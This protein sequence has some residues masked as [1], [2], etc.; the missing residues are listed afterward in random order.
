MLKQSAI[1]ATILHIVVNLIKHSTIVIY[2]P[3]AVLTTNL[4]ILQL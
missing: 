2:E 3:R 1:G 4:P